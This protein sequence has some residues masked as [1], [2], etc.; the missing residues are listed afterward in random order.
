MTDYKQGIDQRG[1]VVSVWYERERTSGGNP[2]ATPTS[3]DAQ[4]IYQFELGQYPGY[5]KFVV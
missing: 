3:T 4:K 5:G 2:R 1:L